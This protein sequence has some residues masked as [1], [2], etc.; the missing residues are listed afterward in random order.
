V[1]D[2]KFERDTDRDR[3]SRDGESE[4][5]NSRIWKAK[6]FYKKKVC[7]FCTQKQL[8][9]DYKEVELLKRFITERGKIQPRRLM[10]TC[11]KHQRAVARAIKRARMVALL[12]FVAD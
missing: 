2:D 9:I 7:K 11:A 1:T 5:K 4:E 12:P 8:K 6:V 10:G 3:Q